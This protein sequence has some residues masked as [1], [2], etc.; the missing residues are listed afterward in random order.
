MFHQ[1]SQLNARSFV[2]FHQSGEADTD[3]NPPSKNVPISPV[4]FLLVE[5]T[6]D[7]VTQICDRIAHV[8][9]QAPQHTSEEHILIEI[10]E[11][12]FHQEIFEAV[13]ETY[14]N[15]PVNDELSLDGVSAVLQAPAAKT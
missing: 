3:L 11:S 14:I 7:W 2:E 9:T 10:Y 12:R 15:R 8:T 13:C 5:H 6:S 1:Q 4:T